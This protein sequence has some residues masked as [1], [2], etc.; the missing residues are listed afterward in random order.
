MIMC[1]Y[2]RIC[3]TNRSLVSGDGAQFDA[4]LSQL[5]HIL[6]DGGGLRPDCIILREKDLN[7]QQY[8]LL[9]KQVIA[10]CKQYD[11]RC[12]LHTFVD[13]AKALGH[14]YIHVPFAQFIEMQEREKAIFS[15]IG[16]ST[17]TVL[18]AKIAEEK[19]ASYVTTSPIYETTCKPGAKAKG[20][21]FL[22]EVAYSVQ[23]PVYALGGIH[24]EDTLQCMA[25]GASGVCMMSEY[26][27][28]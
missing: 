14:K 8:T 1:T 20:L 25:S 7:S 24:E 19:G 21:D 6:R 23:I 3:I 27:R 17:H 28:S 9:A 26:M 15:E 4:L 13:V 2:K 16:V 22:R 18:E 12:M 11:V 5:L 10:L